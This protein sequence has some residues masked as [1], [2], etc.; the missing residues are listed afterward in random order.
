[1][2]I[3]KE[4]DLKK[5]RD[6]AAVRG[7]KRMPKGRPFAPYVTPYPYIRVSDFSNGS[8]R[9]VDLKYVLPEDQK[10]IKNYRIFAEDLYISIAGTLGAVGTIPIG[11][12]G[13]QLTENAARVV[14]SDTN[15]VYRDF[16]KEVLSTNRIQSQIHTARGIGG[17]VPKLALFRIEDFDIPLPPMAE[18]KQ[19]VAILATWDRAK[20]QAQKLIDAKLRLKRGLMQQLLTGK[21]RF[22]EFKGS[23]RTEYRLGDIFA[24]RVE[25][26]GNHLPLLSI[27][28]D[29]GIVYRDDLAKKDTSPEDKGKY[30]RIVP[31]DIG[32]NTMRMWQGVSAL[33][34]IEGIVSP[35]YTVVIPGPEM[36]GEFAAYL[37]KLPETI[38]LFHRYSQGLVDDTLNLKFPLFAK[39]RVTIPTIAEQKRIVCCLKAIDNE[40]EVYRK[41][42]ANYQQQKRGLMQVLLT[43]K[44][45]VKV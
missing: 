19:I 16:L 42:L 1:M 14:I 12:D 35:A 9:E 39:V 38:H 6:V 15:R 7:G 28:A 27:T 4:W 37:F 23:K 24:E 3:P 17:G 26:D 40:I 18:Q 32:Y 2:R 10:A 22:A 5:L 21:M 20:E 13:A 31:G 29:R 8:V 41:L 45:R 11:L 36:S 43:G 25:I 30:K 34:S 33:S 44:V